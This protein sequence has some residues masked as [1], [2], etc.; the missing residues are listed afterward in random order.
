MFLFIATS[1]NPPR[2]SSWAGFRNSATTVP[3][4]GWPLTL[5][6]HCTSGTSGENMP[7][8][9][10]AAHA[11]PLLP[12]T[13]FENLGERGSS[14]AFRERRRRGRKLGR[15]GRRRS[16]GGAARAQWFCQQETRGTGAGP[17]GRLGAGLSRAA[18]AAAAAAAHCAAG[19]PRSGR[20]LDPRAPG[21]GEQG[22]AAPRVCRQPQ[23][24]E[25]AAGHRAVRLRRL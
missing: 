7:V 16:G 19:W 12:A 13:F 4:S 3:P 5:P 24:D 20:A 9:A 22:A 6:V 10:C 15:Q 17:R 18:A 8:R 23:E 11:P 14:C 1:D 2:V 21:D 25:A